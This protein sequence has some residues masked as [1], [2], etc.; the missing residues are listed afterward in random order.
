MRDVILLNPIMGFARRMAMGFWS[1]WKG[2]SIIINLLPIKD[3]NDWSRFDLGLGM[4]KR[5]N[6]MSGRQVIHIQ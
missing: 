2:Q 4:D 6:W 3:G 5:T 1:I